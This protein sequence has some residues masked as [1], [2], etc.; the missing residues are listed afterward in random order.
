TPW[1]MSQSAT[2]YAEGIVFH[3]TAGHGGFKLDRARNAGMDPALRLSGGWYEEDAEWALVAAGYPDMF[4]YREQ[5][6]ADR[7]MR[8]WYPDAWEA[9]HGRTL[10]AAE[11]FT[12]GRQQFARRH[13]KDWV[14]ISAVR[15][16]DH[17]GMV[18]ALA[19]VGGD[20]NSQE[21]RR[22]L[23]RVGEYAAGRHGFVIIPALHQNMSR[24]EVR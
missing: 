17:P 24:A 7:A 9:V 11:S 20:R 6:M 12:R 19:T 8:D 15:S 22:F 21:T 23:V 4:T 3:S 2:I 1:G 14:V 10:S 5:A 13:A 16:S 18:E